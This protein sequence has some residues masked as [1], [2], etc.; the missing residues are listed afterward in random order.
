MKK[1]LIIF[2]SLISIILSSDLFAVPA[3]PDPLQIKQP[4]GTI[5]TVVLKGDEFFN[6]YVTEDG[7]PIVKDD[8]GIF[9]YASIDQSGRKI[10]TKVKANNEALRSKTEKEFINTLTNIPDVGKINSM[11]R[12]KRVISTASKIAI[13]SHF[14]RTG[15]P[16]SLVILV[17]FSDLSFVTSNPKTAFTEKLN[18]A[19]YSENGATGSVRDY[20]LDNSS[21]AFSPQFDVVGPFTLLHP[22]TYYG[23]N[24]NSGLDIRPT[25]MIADACKAAFDS[26]IDFT[27]YD[28]DGD[29]IVDNVFVYYAGHNEAENAGANKIW[30]HRWGIYPTAMY[31][32]GNYTGT[33]ASVTFNGKRVEDYACTS[34]LRGNS[35]TTMAGIGTFTHEFGH[36]LGLDD[37]YPTN[38]NTHHTLSDW[39]IMDAG[40]YNNLG[41]T[42]PSYNAF[43]RF[44]LGYL[45]PTLLI[46]NENI[47]LNPLN[48]SNQA[49]MISP[50]DYHNLNPDSPSPTEFFLLE[51]RQKTG[52]DAYLPGHG[53]LIYRINFNKTDFDNN[54]PNNDPNKMGVDLIE[55][56]KI[57]SDGTLSG[58]PFPGS[59]SI[60]SYTP[61][62]RNGTELSNKPITMIVEQDNLISFRYKGGRNNPIVN[63]S[64]NFAPFSTEFGTPSVSQSVTIYGEKLLAD[65]QLSFE[66]GEHFEMKKETDP[67]SMWTESML[68]TPLDSVVSQTKILVRYNPASPSYFFTHTNNFRAQ[69][70]LSEE[71]SVRLIAESLAPPT[72]L[73]VK[74]ITYQSFV[75]N[76]NATPG[77]TG[78]LL[79]VSLINANGEEQPISGYTDKWITRTYDTV[80]NLLSDAEYIFKVKA[81]S[82]TSYDNGKTTKFSEIFNVQ[83]LPYP[84]DKELR[85]VTLKN[86]IVNVFVPSEDYNA[87]GTADTVEVFNVTGQ[88]LKS[89]KI[90]GEIVE[91]SDL[92]RKMVLIIRL[93]KYRTKTIILAE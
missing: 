13:P 45:V 46:D 44:Q 88:K 71:M 74:D 16:R 22:Y 36:V 35:G 15:S 18:K 68:L 50:N 53:M 30:P 1:N 90:A 58:D 34:E 49:F 40:A 81:S 38:S 27:T 83:T 5:L 32:G 77:A 86:G 42:P 7:Y 66:N 52:W 79:T 72:E 21:G 41:R 67:E 11:M 47:V 6:Y 25:Q 87:E 92:P 2:I 9:N 20:F 10:D 17:N 54:Q 60:K 3:C 73:A 29:N 75:A 61:S 12:A 70:L 43:E 63:I 24:D 82:K 39:C 31:G 55:A 93:G 48:I 56:D 80:Y 89:V 64:N 57:P 23:E 33:I 51:N 84:F 37:M 28:T 85:T 8:A 69:S 78:Y 65:I 14:P 19:G 59:G 62:L 26:G 91:I 4:D 76:W